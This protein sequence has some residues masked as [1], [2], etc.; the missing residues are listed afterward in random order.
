MIPLSNPDLSMTVNQVT[1][2]FMAVS[3][4]QILHGAF[5]FVPDAR[6]EIIRKRFPYDE[7]QRREAAT[8][9]VAVTPWAEWSDLAGDLYRAGE[10]AAITVFRVQLPILKGDIH[11]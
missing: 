5:R 1:P 9:Y 11:C 8:Y 3:N 6:A 2:V 7:D 4:W 10:T